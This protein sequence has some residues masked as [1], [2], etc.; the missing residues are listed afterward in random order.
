M[1]IRDSSFLVY[2]VRYSREHSLQKRIQTTSTASA[3]TSHFSTRK[4]FFGFRITM[5][6][7]LHV[8][9]IVVASMF[10]L[11]TSF[12]IRGNIPSTV[13][14]LP[15]LRR[16]MTTS[17]TGTVY[18]ADKEPVVILFTKEGCTLCDKVKDVLFIV[19]EENPHSL[20][21]KDITDDSDLYERY[22]YDIPVLHLDGK[23]WTKHRLTID[24]AR[25]AL[26]Q[27]REGLFESPPGEPNAAKLERKRE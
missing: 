12:I 21:Q 22:K 16:H 20:L 2:F 23:Y 17:V 18:Q 19:R 11:A 27:A 26:V 25:N 6:V 9:L 8:R 14:C 15:T 1:T 5:V 13:K 4:S 3:T 10:R 7:S 24:E